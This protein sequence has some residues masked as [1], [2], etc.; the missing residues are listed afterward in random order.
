MYKTKIKLMWVPG[1]SGIRGN[2][3]ADKFANNAIRNV[4]QYSKA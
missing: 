3:I 2:E 1:H 4:Y